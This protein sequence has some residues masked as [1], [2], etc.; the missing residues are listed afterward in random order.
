LLTE[1]IAPELDTLNALTGRR[2]VLA[3]ASDSP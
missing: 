3:L 1:R 2:Y